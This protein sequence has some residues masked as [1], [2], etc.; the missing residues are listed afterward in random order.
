MNTE[1]HL[2]QSL[3][4][5]TALGAPLNS[6]ENTDI[7][8]HSGIILEE[9]QE[10]ADGL[11]DSIVTIAGFYN[12]KNDPETSKPLLNQIENLRKAIVVAGFSE[13]YIANEVQRAN[14]SK[15]CETLDIAERTQLKYLGDGVDTIIKKMP[16]GQYMVYSSK[17]QVSHSGKVFMKNKFLKSVEWSDPDYTNPEEWIENE[18]F[19]SV[20]E[21]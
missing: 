12:D 17:D 8:S 6:G 2:Q 14:L 21:Y 3:E 5:R 9:L 18:E 15:R 11:I 19:L 13:E 20:L 7:R 1:T 10:A 4:L 16:D